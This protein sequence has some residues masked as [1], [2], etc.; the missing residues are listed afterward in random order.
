MALKGREAPLELSDQ[1]LAD[2]EGQSLVSLEDEK[3]L[4]ALHKELQAVCRQANRLP[5][6]QGLASAIVKRAL[7]LGSLFRHKLYS[8]LIILRQLLMSFLLGS[9]CRVISRIN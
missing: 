2:S 1:I 4:E 8:S 5:R 9:F 7:D 3:R 6:I